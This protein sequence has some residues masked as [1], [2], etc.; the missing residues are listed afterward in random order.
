MYRN[1]HNSR[2]SSTH[3]RNAASR[4]RI[5]LIALLLALAVGTA[6]LPLAQAAD[7]GLSILAQP[8]ARLA[9]P[10]AQPTALRASVVY[11]MNPINDSSARSCSLITENR[12]ENQPGA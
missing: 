12:A 10:T 1:F 11:I 3:D 2:G 6:Q 4:W 8:T 9:V 7:P 5:V